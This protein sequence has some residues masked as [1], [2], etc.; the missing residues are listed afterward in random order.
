[1]LK[2][3]GASVSSILSLRKGDWQRTSRFSLLAAVTLFSLTMVEIATISLFLKRFG[4]DYLPYMYV[5]SGLCVIPATALYSAA[6]QRWT[7]DL[8]FQVL[9]LGASRRNC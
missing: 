4:V 7:S 6:L 2:S 9:F 5:L 1:M 8:L 3:L